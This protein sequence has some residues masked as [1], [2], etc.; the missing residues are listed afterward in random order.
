[1]ALAAGGAAMASCPNCGSC[2]E[3]Q[4]TKVE[5]QELAAGDYT[6]LVESPAHAAGGA[7]FSNGGLALAVARGSGP[8]VA[9][10][11]ALG[12]LGRR[13]RALLG[14]ADLR[15]VARALGGA[16]AGARRLM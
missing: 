14:E 1:M 7:L 5:P 15:G 2:A 4:P 11:G 16:L 10:L 8:A 3:G 6:V 13:A 9:Q 12:T